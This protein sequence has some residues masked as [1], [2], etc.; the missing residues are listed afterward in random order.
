[1]ISGQIF[2]TARTT[3]IVPTPP[4]TTD[5]TGPSQCATRPDSNPPNAS[6]APTTKSAFTAETRPRFSSG[7]SNC[8]DVCRTTMLTPSVA[9]Q[10][11]SI[12]NE[13]QNQ[14]DNPKPTVATPNAATA[15]SSARPARWS[16][17]RCASSSA[18]LQ[19]AG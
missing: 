4:E 14:R 8:T 11:T 6:D 13:G 3:N 16:G 2:A 7:T 18:Q 9:P 10:M 15:K 19:R 1:M 17:G 5:S 12:A